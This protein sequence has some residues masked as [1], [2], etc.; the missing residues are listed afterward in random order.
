MIQHLKLRTTQKNVVRY[1]KKIYLFF[2][3][4]LQQCESSGLKPGLSVTL[5]TVSPKSVVTRATRRLVFVKKQKQKY[6][7]KYKKLTKHFIDNSP[8]ID[9]KKITLYVLPRTNLK[10][11]YDLLTKTDNHSIH[12]PLIG[13]RYLLFQKTFQNKRN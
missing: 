10:K 5:S 12:F 1:K 8:K 6:K 11:K 7:Y 9:M 4:F 3:V 2:F 13:Q